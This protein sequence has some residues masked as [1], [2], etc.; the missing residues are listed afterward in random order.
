[1]STKYD[2]AIELCGVLKRVP[3]TGWVRSK[4]EHPESIADHS[5]RTA[6]LAMMICPEGVNKSKAVQMALIHDAAEAI[7]SDITPYDGVS[8]EDKFQRED[9]AWTEICDSFGDHEMQTIWREM[10][11]GKTPEAIF[12]KELDKLEMLIQAEEYENLQEGL[13]L[14]DF[15][16]N[17]DN[18]FTYST[19]KDIYEAIKTRRTSRGK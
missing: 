3:R 9:R 4:V 13:D 6:Y 1:M 19:T 17:F 14:S 18:F 7:V 8:L 16:R 10:E 2:K 5:M 11:E 15:F 12:V